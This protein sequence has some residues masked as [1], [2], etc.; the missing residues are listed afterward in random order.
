MLD[1]CGKEE[2]LKAGLEKILVAAA[3]LGDAET[4]RDYRQHA[5][6]SQCSELKQ[7]LKDLFEILRSS[8]SVDGARVDETDF[9]RL[10]ARAQATTWELKK[11]VNI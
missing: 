8:D 3:S 10:G 5:I 6:I 2:G 9:D 7:K 4:T 11:E 1:N